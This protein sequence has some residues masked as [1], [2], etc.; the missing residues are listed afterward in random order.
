VSELDL[1]VDLNA[2]DDGLGWSTLAD[3]AAP[4]R[5]VPGAMVLA[6]NQS[7]QAFASS[8]STRTAMFTSPSC[9]ARSPRTSTCS[10]IRSHSGQ[11]PFHDDAHTR[12]R[13]PAP[14]R[15]TPTAAAN[16]AAPATPP[17]APAA[18]PPSRR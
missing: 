18:E 1:V 11:H 4:E 2:E 13:M 16:T 10:A 12:I 15:V 8:P 5:I 14:T 6:G 7:A 9:P 17:T 3:A